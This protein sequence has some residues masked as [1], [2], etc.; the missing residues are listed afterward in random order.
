MANDKMEM[1]LNFGIN[2]KENKEN[3]NY[4]QTY[5]WAKMRTTKSH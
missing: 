1:I 2:N 5:K 4:T 3:T